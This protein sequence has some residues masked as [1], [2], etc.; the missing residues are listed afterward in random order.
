MPPEYLRDLR[1][2]SR[3]RDG[4][5]DATEVKNRHRTMGKGGKSKGGKSTQEIFV[6]DYCNQ[7]EGSFALVA[8]HE[9]KCKPYFESLCKVA[10]TFYDKPAGKTS[11]RADAA[12][13]AH[14][15]GERTYGRTAKEK[16]E[17]AK[18]RRREA[19][20]LETADERLDD[21]ERAHLEKSTGE[22]RT[23][24]DAAATVS[25]R[26]ASANSDAP[27]LGGPPSK[28]E[29]RKAAKRKRKEA[30]REEALLKV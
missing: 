23:A 11:D 1:D 27:S 13:T 26:D 29:R 8:Q 16:R 9:R 21:V 22:V 7:F 18:K 14:E 30:E 19:L 3:Y 20:G 24:T 17:A 28:A 15:K 2:L 12:E 5:S 25:T 10:G 6:C 4:A